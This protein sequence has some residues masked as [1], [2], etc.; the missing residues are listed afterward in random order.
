[1]DRNQQILELEQRISLLSEELERANAAN[2]AKET[3]LSNM[4]HD[5]RT[6]MNAI[7]GMTAL[8]RKHIDEKTRVIDALNKIETASGHLLNLINDVLDMSRINSGRM[9]LN[10]QYFYISDLLHDVMV[11]T[12]PMA[13]SR[14]HSLTL[15]TGEF[16]E[17]RLLG[18]VLH[19]RQIYVNIISNS[20][21]Y[22]PEGGKITVYF[23]AEKKGELC[24]LRFVCEDNGIGMSE[25][26]LSRIF[27]PF[28]RVQN[29]TLSGVEG[30]GLGMSI[31][32]R[33]VE[34]MDGTIRVESRE[35]E[36]TK[37]SIA[38]PMKYEEDL[39]GCKAPE[40][41]RFLVIESDEH[42]RE[43]FGRYLPEYGAEYT[44]VT[45]VREA[46]SAITAAQMEGN[47]YDAAIIGNRIGEEGNI[48]EFASYLR[49]SHPE[50]LRI[51]ASDAS[52]GDIEFQAVRSGIQHFIPVP[53][54]KRSLYV[55]LCEA[56][57]SGSRGDA[58]NTLP[59]LNG[60]HILLA[61]D[62]MI[63]REIACE[64][65]S[66][67][68][69]VIDTAE[70]GRKAADAYLAS[71]EGYYDLILMDIHMPVLDGYASTEL[72]RSSGR[73]DAETVPVYAMTANTFAEDI[74]RAREAGMNG[75]IAKPIDISALM[76]ILRQVLVRRP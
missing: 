58:E 28:E 57:H 44:A 2:A 70:D 19:L 33:L 37:V 45:S 34:S 10:P 23:E 50:I 59:D 76:Q 11:I 14:K 46:F 9:K 60:R 5:I 72:I 15:K 66:G 31:V 6:P 69:A 41:H 4:S 8:A 35:G 39:V 1:M 17:E 24:E 65:I 3:F 29:S 12:Q 53:F 38:V 67:T 52:W 51:L 56:F 48:F 68:G 18:D 75:H 25:E 22:T 20:V 26:F 16:D 71:P 47:A 27:V 55:N 62:N 74:N 42:Q 30:T 43:L 64:I 36:G 40:K 61:E 21:K 13:E 54:F 49:D 32:K 73:R 7:V 63:N